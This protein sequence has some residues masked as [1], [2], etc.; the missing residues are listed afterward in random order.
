MVAAAVESGAS[1]VPV[2]EEADLVV[3]VASEATVDVELSGTEIAA[4]V[5]VV[6]GP[7]VSL[8]GAVHAASTTHT[9]TDPANHLVPTTHL[10]AASVPSG[11]AQ[12]VEDNGPTALLAPRRTDARLPL[13]PSSLSQPTRFGS[14]ASR[15]GEEPRRYRAHPPRGQLRGLGR[16]LAPNVEP[17]HLD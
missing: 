10:H 16:T 5:A 15:Q 4:A 12:Q 11:T 2:V 8:D 14:A 13:Q 6:S 1:I 17:P 7:V 3:L 9:T